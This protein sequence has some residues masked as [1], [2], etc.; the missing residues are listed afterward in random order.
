MNIIRKYLGLVWMLLAPGVIVFLLWQASLKIG[1]AAT[2][3][4]ANITL[5]WVII[6]LIFIPVCIGLFIFGYYA[7]KGYYNNSLTEK[8]G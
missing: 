1:L 7:F 8:S 2:A 5:Q 6:L 3:A 4:K